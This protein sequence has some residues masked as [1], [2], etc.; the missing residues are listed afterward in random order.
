MP[1]RRGVFDMAT[2]CVE[3]R[4][5]DFCA[6]GK[7]LRARRS[8]SAVWQGTCAK[9]KKPSEVLIGRWLDEDEILRSSP[10]SNTLLFIILPFT[11]KAIWVLILLSSSSVP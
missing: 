1:K 9:S 6:T 2:R 3:L 8:L 10:L 5:G 7:E 4:A 11:A